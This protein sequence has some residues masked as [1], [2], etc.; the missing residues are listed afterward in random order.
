MQEWN[1][2]KVE[3]QETAF[4]HELF[5]AQAAR[6]PESVAVTS[7]NESLTYRELDHRANQLAQY[8]QVLGVRPEV[9][10]GICLERSIGLVVAV[11]AILKSG[12][13]CLPLDP[14]LPNDRLS[15]MLAASR[16]PPHLNGGTVS[17]KTLW[18]RRRRCLS[19]RD[20]G[21]PESAKER[22]TGERI[23]RTESG[24]SVLHLRLGR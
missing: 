11:L 8:L 18:L 13:A 1:E 9:S 2:I 17:F 21:S 20:P 14:G 15:F 22:I 3:D 4:L 7:Q 23:N 16:S 6:T 19:G 24:A 10:V 5:E 12:G